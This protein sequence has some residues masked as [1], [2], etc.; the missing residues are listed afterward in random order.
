MGQLS[1]PH[2]AQAV[3]HVVAA[4][5]EVVVQAQ[6]VLVEDVVGVGASLVGQ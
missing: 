1:R 5:A 2:R 4:A 3:H 6:V